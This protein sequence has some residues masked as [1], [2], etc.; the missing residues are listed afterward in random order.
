MR[1]LIYGSSLVLGIPTAALAQAAPS[2][3]LVEA[4]VVTAARHQ[5]LNLAAAAELQRTPGGVSLIVA[6]EHERRTALALDDMLRDAP[7]VYAQRRWGSD[8]RISIRGSGLGAAHHNRGVILAQDGVP[9]NEA[10]GFGDSQIVDPLSVSF[11]EVYRGG[12]AL[13]FGGALLGGAVNMVTPTGR[14]A[15][16]RAQARIDAG[17]YGLAR[18]N[19]QVAGHNSSW[20]AYASAT[21]QVQQGWRPQSQQNLQLATVNLGRSF[22]EDREVRLILGGASIHQEMPGPLTAAELAADPRQASPAYYAG[23]YGRHIRSV[24]ASLQTRWRLS[25]SVVAEA[26]LHGAWKD[27]DHPIVQ[28]I[29]QE[30]RNY[31]GWLRLDA[32]GMVGGLGVDGLAGAWLRTGDVDSHFYASHAGARGALQSSAYPRATALDVFAEGRAWLTDNLALVAGATWGHAGRHFQGQPAGGRPGPAVSAERTYQWFAPRIGLLWRPKD[33]LQVFGNLTKS[34]EPP[35]FG[36][37]SPS[38]VGFAPIASQVAWTGE[39][40]V[41]GH[42]GP[43]HL[44]ITAYRAELE[45]EL[46]Q[47]AAGPGAPAITVN[48]GRTLHQ[49]LEA[50]VAWRISPEWRLHQVYTFSDFRFRDDPTYG[51]N[52]LPV[53]PKHF[54]RAE[55][56]YDHPSGW[57]VAPS[58]EWSASDIWVDYANTARAPAYAVWNLN[59]GWMLASSVLAFVDVRNLA[60]STYVSNVQPVARAV[61]GPT[62]YYWPGDARGIYGGL[63]VTF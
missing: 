21:H 49:G 2:D 42:L 28:V 46:L 32:E 61:N 24:R 8:V 59:A 33:G 62:G 31:G 23:D 7:G 25:P 11:T 39:V 30:S 45:N 60:N 52:R 9:L 36:A 17:S 13:R 22:G 15:D 18:T 57:F 43:V 12:N 10:D 29:D 3:T 4:L 44:D 41:R 37:L 6:E 35:N 47:Q 51:D 26:A 34:V 63:R 54:Y 27:L 14:T 58:V 20:D 55:L 56:R 50:M 1:I 5:P 38:N 48:A 40:G 19:L 53:A 16:F